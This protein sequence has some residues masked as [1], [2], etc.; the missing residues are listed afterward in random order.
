M[1]RKE[2]SA[3]QIHLGDGSNSLSVSTTSGIDKVELNQVSKQII[4]LAPDNIHAPVTKAIGYITSE[5]FELADVIIATLESTNSLNFEANLAIKS[6]K[7]LCSKAP[8]ILEVDELAQAK[9]LSKSPLVL[10]LITAVQMRS[11]TLIGEPEKAK[12]RYQK[13]EL[14]GEISVNLYYRSLAEKSELIEYYDK[15]KIELSLTKL[16]S[17]AYGLIRTDT[18]EYIEK[19]SKDL[20]KYREL[21]HVS[22]VILLCNAIKINSSFFEKHFWY[23]SKK[24][25]NLLD[26]VLHQIKDEIR[27]NNIDDNFAQIVAVFLHNTDFMDKELVNL[28]SS[29]PKLINKLPLEVKEYLEFLESED[30]EALSSS[31]FKSQ[32]Q[33]QNDPKT[34]ESSKLKVQETLLL[35]ALEYQFI[36][37]LFSNEEI[38]D[39][40]DEGLSVE[41]EED[42]VK[43]VCKLRLSLVSSPKN[44][45][46]RIAIEA[47]AKP[48]FDK[49]RNEFI[50]LRPELLIEI[51]KGL[52]A[53]ELPELSLNYIDSVF[54]EDI[55]FSPFIDSY[56]DVLSDLAQFSKLE[57]I[58]N[59]YSKEEWSFN[60]WTKKIRL[61]QENND[62][63][64]EVKVLEH[65]NNF[66]K[67]N[68]SVWA[69]LLVA[70]EKLGWV[71]KI[72]SVKTEI[73]KSVF[74]PPSIHA[75][76]AF[77]ILI[78]NGDFEFVEPIIMDLFV[79]DP[80]ST[81]GPLTDLTLSLTL[82][83]GDSCY[84]PSDK[85]CRYGLCYILRGKKGQKLTKLIVDDYKG[86]HACILDSS[87]PN[88]ELLAHKKVGDQVSFGID[89]YE[90]IEITPPFLGAAWRIAPSLR[91]AL[92]DGSDAFQ[93]IELPTEKNAVES[94]TEALAKL[95]PKKD[96]SIIHNH[97]L[98]PIQVK[99]K[100]LGS[101]D[102]VESALQ[103]TLDHSCVK[104]GM[105]HLGNISQNM[106]LDVYSAVFISI[107]GIFHAPSFLNTKYFM[108]PQ[109]ESAI[110]SWLVGSKK[111]VGRAGISDEG[112]LFLNDAK[113]PLNIKIIE[114]LEFLLENSSACNPQ[115]IDLPIDLVKMKE[116]VDIST[117]SSLSA[118]LSL[119][120]DFLS[121]DTQLRSVVAEPKISFSNAQ[122]FYLTLFD[123]LTLSDKKFCL[124]I[125]HDIKLNAP[126]QYKTLVDLIITNDPSSL[127]LVAN[128]LQSFKINVNQLQDVMDVLALVAFSGIR[129]C[130]FADNIIDRGIGEKLLFSA[131]ASVIVPCGDER[132]MEDLVAELIIRV[133]EKCTFSKR[134]TSFGLRMIEDFIHGYFLDMTYIKKIIEMK[135]TSNKLPLSQA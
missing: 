112:T 85:L 67:E 46:S 132:Y 55:W 24:E 66:Y 95:T 43:S 27:N 49:Y 79:S 116:F 107:S 125:L 105:T 133:I 113:H 61:L 34:K 83:G 42:I 7:L 36:E 14:H 63:E 57:K 99:G 51:S 70:Y 73:P 5:N 115:L 92:N 117:F 48:T 134:F 109:T 94:M 9:Y 81:S 68:L 37:E 78:K 64:G 59:S 123:E 69:N 102:L 111:T 101:I 19:I 114:G 122:S 50:N 8:N 127:L 87:S 44:S 88:A 72:R 84:K 126:V 11:D 25:K 91:S 119:G 80:D 52:A 82:H 53:R 26:Q 71:E 89:E 118:S 21:P 15:N 13:I 97:P 90:I 65:L 22:K 60:G 56:I 104:N 131:F 129:Q 35:S 33:L 47:L 135:L 77:F 121:F 29:S 12:E 28:S 120:F 58:L 23:F 86:N 40:L 1:H 110:Q 128:L 30:I 39:L 130:Y 3:C 100:L 31:R 18:V 74:Y 4:S 41:A 106:I 75:W 103:V 17:L 32:V 93:L 62:L 20:N 38:K 16:I 54:R 96:P 98:L 45:E 10:D 124:T 6:L 108:T 2:L 76:Q